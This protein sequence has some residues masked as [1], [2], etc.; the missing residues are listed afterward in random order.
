MVFWDHGLVSLPRN[1]AGLHMCGY[2]SDFLPS[3]NVVQGLFIMGAWLKAKLKC[4]A[5]PKIPWPCWNFQVVVGLSHPTQMLGFLSMH[6]R[7]P[8][9]TVKDHG[10][11]FLPRNTA[12]I[13][14]F[15]ALDKIKKLQWKSSFY[16]YRKFWWL[17]HA[18][19]VVIF[20]WLLLS[21][22]PWFW[23]GVI[24]FLRQNSQKDQQVRHF[25]CNFPFLG[26]TS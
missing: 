16:Y 11:V 9:P 18:L 6:V 13:H 4:A 17:R 10:V 21:G 5:G 7:W 2:M 22:F 23:Q 12:K 8:W 15:S 20:P 3:Q 24:V 1:T 14:I 25:F 26:L 19:E